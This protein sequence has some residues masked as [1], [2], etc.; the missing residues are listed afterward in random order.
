MKQ[1]GKHRVTNPKRA[2]PEP[3]P[4]PAAQPGVTPARRKTAGQLPPEWLARPPAD[5]FDFR[6]R[7]D[8]RVTYSDD[9]LKRQRQYD[10][11]LDR[12]DWHRMLRAFAGIL[13]I[14]IAAACLHRFLGL[15]PAATTEFT[16]GGVIA[17]GGGVMLRTL[18]PMLHRRGS[19]RHR[20]RDDSSS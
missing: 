1:S 4:D 6:E 15:P 16:A 7:T 17:T 20:D 12:M 2:Q 3:A 9:V 8:W 10:E 18:V 14:G 13:G 11:H 5:E 19:Q